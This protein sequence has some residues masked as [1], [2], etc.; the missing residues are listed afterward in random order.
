MNVNIISDEEGLSKCAWCHKHISDDVEVF[1]SGAT[2]TQDMDLSEYE[3]YCIQIHLVS[4]E[5]PIYMMV[6]AEGSDA[7]KD[8]NDAMFLFCSEACG[9]KLKDVLDKEMSLGNM[10]GTA[11]GD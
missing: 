10:F 4:E 8:G 9:Q 11:Q 3:G 7:K 1:G 2:L 6:T 5:K